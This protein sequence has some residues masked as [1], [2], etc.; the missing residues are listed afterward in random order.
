[1]ISV[2][3]LS[4][5]LAAAAPDPRA[6]EA[7]T[8]SLGSLVRAA[9]E[10][11][12]RDAALIGPPGEELATVA[13]H[14]GC[15]FV[16]ANSLGEGLGAAL[17]ATRGDIVFALEGGYA[18]PTGF[19]EEASDLLREGAGFSGALLRRAPHD[20]ATR[21]APGL[22]RPVGFLA[23]REALRN[24][25]GRDLAGLIRQVRPR[26]TLVVRAIRTV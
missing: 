25:G 1:M 8:R 24:F 14:A 17:S 20:L 22:A 13:D 6:A 16:E 23:R 21:F 5:S 2:L 26:R 7:L 4:P 12:V 10:G 9:M 18:L 3:V 11:V 19:I 15:A